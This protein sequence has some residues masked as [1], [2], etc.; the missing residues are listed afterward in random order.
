MTAQCCPMGTYGTDSGGYP[1][2]VCSCP[3]D[4]ACMCVE[5]ICDGWGD[6]DDFPEYELP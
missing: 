6:G 5:C 1:R 4:C 2:A 3:E